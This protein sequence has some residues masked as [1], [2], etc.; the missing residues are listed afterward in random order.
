MEAVSQEF[1]LILLTCHLRSPFPLALLL[2]I[3]QLG[4][5]KGEEVQWR[6]ELQQVLARFQA[7]DAE[8]LLC[9]Y[10]KPKPKPK[11]LISLYLTS[12]KT[13]SPLCICVLLC[14]LCVL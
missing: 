13:L 11:Y 4:A 8:S 9:T 10:K 3:Y 12:V 1:V 2:N 5:T 14:V 6:Q 7:E